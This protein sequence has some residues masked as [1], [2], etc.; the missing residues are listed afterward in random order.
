MPSQ[1]WQPRLARRC[2]C[3]WRRQQE[4]RLDLLVSQAIASRLPVARLQVDDEAF[5]DRLTE[6]PPC[7]GLIQIQQLGDLVGRGA[8]VGGE[9]GGCL[10][11][12]VDSRPIFF[13]DASAARAQSLW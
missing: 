4:L 8:I 5:E 6:A 11:H 10:L 12:R 2:D 1:A 9:I 7:S 13:R 3:F